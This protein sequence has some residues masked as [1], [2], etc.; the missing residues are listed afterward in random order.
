MLTLPT[1]VLREI[2]DHALA[3]HPVEAC[4][5]VAGPAG[6]DRPDRVVRMRNAEASPRRF[7]FD[8][9]EQLA[10]WREMDARGEDPVVVYHSHTAARAY[11]STTDEAFLCDPAV[12]YVIVSTRG[13]EIDV[14]SYRHIDGQLVPEPIN[15]LEETHVGKHRKPK[16]N[17]KNNTTSQAH[18]LPGDLHGMWH[19]DANGGDGGWLT[20]GG[21]IIVDTLSRIGGFGSDRI[22][23]RPAPQEVIAAHNG[24][25]SVQEWATETARTRVRTRNLAR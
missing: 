7:R 1:H 22:D 17:K 8:P 11:P 23:I 2:I 9:E 18:A 19:L 4:G 25:L 15:S 21:R 24:K 13:D 10:V 16:K 20:S 14:R 6:T 3:A 5:I 12:H